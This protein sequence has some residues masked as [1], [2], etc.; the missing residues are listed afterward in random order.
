[1]AWHG[2]AILRGYL[3]GH[4]STIRDHRL[5]SL[6]SALCETVDY[7]SLVKNL[8]RS[9]MALVACFVDFG[10][11]ANGALYIGAVSAAPAF[12]IPLSSS[13]GFIPSYKRTLVYYCPTFSLPQHPH[14]LS[15][16]LTV[17]QPWHSNH[18][19]PYPDGSSCGRS[20]CS[21]QLL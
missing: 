8:A 3:L 5:C 21:L 11:F 12:S 16:T 1:M 13:T 20:T 17:P 4:F 15:F 9:I 6:L 19:G 14:L 18:G 2:M 7:R 10:S